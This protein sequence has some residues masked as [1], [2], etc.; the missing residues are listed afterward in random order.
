MRIK[1]DDMLKEFKRVLVKKGMREE[2][3]QVSA[4]LFAENSLDGVY[5]H[6]VNRFSRVIDYIEKGYIDINAKAKKIGGDGCFE[7]WDGNLGIG[8][9]NAKICM[10][11][12]IELAKEYGVG[13]VAIRNTNHWLRGGAY[14]W[15]AAD[16]GCVGICWTN[17]MPNMPAWGAKDSKIGNNPFVISIP[18]SNGEH[19]VFDGAMSQF[20]YG[21]INEYKIKGIQ[22][23]FPG[24]YDSTGNISTD[25]AEIE[26]TSRVLPIGFWKGSGLSIAL[27]LVATILS[28]G[29]STTDIGRMTEDEF[30][31][32]QVM[33]AIDPGKFNTPE[34]TD[35]MIN[36][37]I[38]DIKASQPANE[39]VKISYPGERVISTRRENLEKGI[40]VIDSIWEEIKSM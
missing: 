17:T 29:N 28:G 3:A 40:P 39:G 16:A 21:K 9:I 32:S 1:F 8:N 4:K 24:G 34:I 38:D 27:D 12:A 18:R 20:S 31:C 19:V 37:V 6:G 23:P 30:G 2:D 11:K 33:I 36:N 15:Q 35:I 14:G 7:R 22:L 25:P 26:K 5:S 10:D 13:V